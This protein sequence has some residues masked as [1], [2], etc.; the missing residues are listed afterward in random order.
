MYRHSILDWYSELDT[1]NKTVKITD[2]MFVW[3]M[4]WTPLIIHMKTDYM[5]D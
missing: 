1:M 2:T 3:Y 4:Q 5:F